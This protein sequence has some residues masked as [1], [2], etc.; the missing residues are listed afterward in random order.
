MQVSTKR[1]IGLALVTGATTV[2]LVA[3]SGPA[4]AQYN[5]GTG[6]K[7][8]KIVMKGKNP[9]FKGPKRISR[10]EKLTIVNKTK[11]KKIGPHT[12]TLIKKGL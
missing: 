4:S 1:R 6:P 5:V 9:T 12:F 3:G 8:I 2:G 11:P 10:G 7:T